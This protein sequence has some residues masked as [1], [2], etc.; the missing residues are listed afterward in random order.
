MS[1]AP[2]S[3]DELASWVGRISKL[4]HE[5]DIEIE[6][7]QKNEDL[8]MRRA[9]KAEAEIERL[10]R[11]IDNLTDHVR[12][13]EA[14]IERLSAMLG[15]EPLKMDREQR[16]EIARLNAHIAELDAAIEKLKADYDYANEWC[17]KWHQRTSELSADNERLRTENEW[18]TERYAALWSA[19]PRSARPPA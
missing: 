6:R 5:K 12:S 11:A 13:R 10:N 18:L 17:W 4:C 16:E 9:I 2:T 1:D 15:D 7:W 8:Q 14:E 3:M 19:I